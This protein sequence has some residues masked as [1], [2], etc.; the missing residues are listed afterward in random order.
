VTRELLAARFGWLVRQEMAAMH[1]WDPRIGLSEALESNFTT[2]FEEIV[3]I[4]AQT[5]QSQL[6]DDADAGTVRHYVRLVLQTLHEKLMADI[7]HP[8]GAGDK[9]VHDK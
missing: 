2:L 8:P 5:A 7:E 3:E 4:V 9:M 1:L 6:T